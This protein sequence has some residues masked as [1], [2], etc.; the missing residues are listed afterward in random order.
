L[1]GLETAV[2]AT[3][4]PP[5]WMLRSG[6]RAWRVNSD[7]AVETFSS[8]KSGSN[9]TR[10]ESGSIDQGTGFGEE[11]PCLGVEEVD[12][13]L[14]EDLQRGLMDGFDV[15]LG[16]QVDRG[17]G[18]N[19]LPPLGLLG[20]RR[21]GATLTLPTAPSPALGLFHSPEANS[22]LL[23]TVTVGLRT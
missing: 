17:E 3:E 19:R 5:M 1:G 18:P 6:L 15:L 11:S 10:A 23:A 20:D 4:L 12:A 7:G 21:S 16:D 2:K 22:A 8:M 14:R 9:L 13:D